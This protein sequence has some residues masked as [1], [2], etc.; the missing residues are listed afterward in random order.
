MT[1][2]GEI[3]AVVNLQKAGKLSQRRTGKGAKKVDTAKCQSASPIVSKQKSKENRPIEIIKDDVLKCSAS[4]SPVGSPEPIVTAVVENSDIKS[5]ESVDTKRNKMSKKQARKN[6]ASSSRKI[7][8]KKSHKGKAG[9]VN[10]L[11][12]IPS[13]SVKDDG[14]KEEMHR[15]TLQADQE[16][17]TDLAAFDITPIVDTP[18]ERP[19]TEP[20]AENTPAGEISE[21]ATAVEQPMA[22]SQLARV[23]E[24]VETNHS[25]VLEAAGQ[26]ACDT[27]TDNASVGETNLPV[28]VDEAAEVQDIPPIPEQVEQIKG[29]A[30]DED[31]NSAETKSTIPIDEGSSDMIDTKVVVH[32][33]SIVDSSQQ[34]TSPLEQCHF[35]DLGESRALHETPETEK[36]SLASSPLEKIRFGDAEL[37]H[38]PMKRVSSVSSSE[39]G[40]ST[41]AI[42]QAPRNHHRDAHPRIGDLEPEANRLDPSESNRWSYRGGF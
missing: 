6:K 11:P 36:S 8:G 24:T 5:S 42:S 12:T 31:A 1:K 20:V 27:A 15:E 22:T 3:L 35:S 10:V 9:T 39:T 2:P 26:G 13:G 4:S 41:M 33:S 17:K 30:S 38:V 29:P 32:E 19:P 18:G 7:E 37:I 23:A 14:I 28:A 25:D 21:K 16:S 34:S 40:I